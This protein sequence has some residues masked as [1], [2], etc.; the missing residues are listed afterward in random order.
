MLKN[1]HYVT[2]VNRPEEIPNLACP[3]VSVGITT[4]F[5]KVC[6]YIFFIRIVNGNLV[7]FP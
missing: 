4:V 2:P 1:S 5:K 6:L 3:G 7:L